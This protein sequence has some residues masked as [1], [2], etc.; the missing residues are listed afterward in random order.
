MQVIIEI[1]AFIVVILFYLFR[2]K[3]N[4]SIQ[5]TTKKSQNSSIEQTRLSF[6]YLGAKEGT[7]D[8]NDFIDETTQKFTFPRYNKNS[9]RFLVQVKDRTKYGTGFREYLGKDYKDK[10]DFATFEKVFIYP[11]IEVE[12]FDDFLERLSV[13]YFDKSVGKF[14]TLNLFDLFY[15]F[16]DEDEREGD[17]ELILDIGYAR[18][19]E[20]L[21]MLTISQPSIPK[22]IYLGGLRKSQLIQLCRDSNIKLQPTIKLLIETLMNVDFQI[23]NCTVKPTN[24][25]KDYFIYFAK[26]YI[27][28]VKRNADRFH[29]LYIKRIIE[30]ASISNDRLLIRKFAQAEFDSKYWMDRLEQKKY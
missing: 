9:K 13:K 10:I 25:L 15:E 21:G 8:K 23:L 22:D 12:L 1:I 19:I 14:E 5:T 7:Y 24:K 29:P 30:E 26:I 18:M 3:R 27:E 20:E 6:L 17:G 4:N 28:E 11:E 2:S 16:L